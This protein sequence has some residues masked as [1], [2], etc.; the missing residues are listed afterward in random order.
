MPSKDFETSLEYIEFG[1]EELADLQ[2]VADRLFANIHD[3]RSSVYQ[4]T[5]YR[6]E[7]SWLRI[8]A[9]WLILMI[10]CVLIVLLMSFAGADRSLCACVAMFVCCIYALVRMKATVVCLVR[11]YQRYAPASV[12]CKCRFEP[13]CSEYMIQAV[14]KYGVVRGLIKGIGRLF[15]CKPGYG[16]FEPLK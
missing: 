13:S 10:L 9:A 5:L 16:G 14:V 3:P 12:R 6:P 1:E 11:I 2:S 15:R 8:A 4:R 7:I